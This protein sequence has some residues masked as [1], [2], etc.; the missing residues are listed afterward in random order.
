[1]KN[2]LTSK[3]TFPPVHCNVFQDYDRLDA[4]AKKRGYH[5]IER[6][7]DDKIATRSG[8]GLQNEHL[9]SGWIATMGDS[10]TDPKAMTELLK[11]KIKEAETRGETIII[12]FCQTGWFSVGYTLYVKDKK[13]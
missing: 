9:H 4:L 13:E 8:T 2:F 7:N 6:R 5:S 11:D 12:G 3:D 10:G 1:L